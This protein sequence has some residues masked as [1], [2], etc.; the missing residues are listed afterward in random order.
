MSFLL[1]IKAEATERGGQCSLRRNGK[2]TGGSISQWKQI[3]TLAP[4][5]FKGPRS[6]QW[7]WDMMDELGITIS[8]GTPRTGPLTASLIEKK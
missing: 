2:K 7:L 6:E 8:G 4:E 5:C 3:E 1:E